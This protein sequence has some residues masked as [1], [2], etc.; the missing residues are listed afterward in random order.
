MRKIVVVGGFAVGAALT[1]APLASAD[2]LGDAVDSEI[3]SLN[4]LFDSEAA[5]AGDTADIVHHAGS[6]DTILPADA[7]VTAD[8][9]D[10]TTLDY[11]LYGLNPIAA[12]IAGDP[13]SYNVFNGALTE[14][15]DA[16]NVE[17]YSLLNPDAAINTIPADDL[18]GSATTIADALGTGTATGAIT[19][20]LTVG[21][22]D[23]SAFF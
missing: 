13:G 20:F 21:F 2:T 5:L 11:E 6:F 19:E 3:T 23:L 17:L 4:S 22:G 16:Y 18:F 14:F 8:A 10:L 9:S 15:S 1:L 7:P 12:G